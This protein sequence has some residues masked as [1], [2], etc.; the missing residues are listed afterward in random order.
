MESIYGVINLD[1]GNVFRYFK[2]LTNAV[3][4][5]NYLQFTRPDAIYDLGFDPDKLDLVEIT[6]TDVCDM[7]FM[8][9]IDHVNKE[10]YDKGRLHEQDNPSCSAVYC[11]P[12]KAQGDNCH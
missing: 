8:A 12:D 3:A 4:Y 11:R 1:G 9:H 5:I 6:L 2:R 10:H 7:D